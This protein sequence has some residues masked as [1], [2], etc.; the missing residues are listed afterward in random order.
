MMP[1]SARTDL[2][3]AHPAPFLAILLLGSLAWAC[4]TPDGV[5]QAGATAEIPRHVFLITVDTLRADHVGAYGYGRDTTP[6]L[7][8]L[9]GR[10]VL[11]ESAVAQWPKTGASFASVFTG[12]YPQTTGLTHKAALRIPDAYLTLPEL[13]QE[14]GFTTLA[15]NSNPVL[16]RHLGWDTGFERYLQTWGEGDSPED[17][18]ALRELSNRRRVNKLALPLLAEHA[19]AERVFAWIHYTDPHAPYL[20]QPGDENPFLGDEIFAEAGPRPVSR[21]MLDRGGIW[22][23]G[24]ND[25]LRYYVAQ[26]DANVRVADAAVQEVLEHL[27]Q[28]GLLEGSLVI[29][30]SDHGESLGEHGSYFEHGPQP[31]NTT[32]EVP[33]VFHAPEGGPPLAAGRRISRAVELIDL[34]PTLL[35]LVFPGLENE[36][37][38]G[39]EGESLAPELLGAPT[40]PTGAA[41][42]SFAFSEAGRSGAHFRSVQDQDWKLI[43]RP[44]R[45]RPGDGKGRTERLELYHL[46]ADP[47]ETENLAEAELERTRELRRRLAGWMRSDEEIRAARGEVEDEGT[48]SLNALRALGYVD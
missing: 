29:F 32:A 39:L 12:R 30:T 13:F 31:Y 26:Y 25:E 24:E 8:A 44:R 1:R 19:G 14:A 10:G 47:L 23:L 21:R 7:D 6:F 2:P 42:A 15:V 11:F 38:A 37:F 5:P 41:E 27:D 33:L 4:T 40:G 43:Y 16:A 9:A 22:R 46:E 3:S 34:Y 18:E 17:P 28:L 48:E 35:D 36:A 45:D 20:L